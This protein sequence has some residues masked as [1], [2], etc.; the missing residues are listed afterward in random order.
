[1]SC[2]TERRAAVAR[3]MKDEGIACALVEDTEGRRDPSLRYL[4]GQ[5]GDAMLFLFDDGS[6]TLAAWDLNMAR[7]MADA[8]DLVALGDYGRVPERVAAGVLERRGLAPGSR[9]SLPASMSH[10]AF[11]RFTAALPAF[12]LECAEGGAGGEIERMRAIK[13][14]AE[15]AILR[16]AC[17]ITDE[18]GLAIERG[19]RGGSIRT[20]GDAALL[21]EA[22]CRRMGCE[23]TGFETLAAGPAR[24]FGIHCF[25]AWTA[26]PFGTAGL[27]ILDFGVKLEGYTSDVTLS[28]VREPLPAG[29]RH[30]VELVRSAYDAARAALRPGVASRDIALLV[31]GIFAAAGAS[32]PHA[33]GHGIGLEAHEAP[34]VRSRADNEWKL[35][36]GMVF[37]LE[38]GLYDPEGGGVRLEDDFL[39]GESAAE[40]LTHSR[41]VEL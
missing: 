18:I 2:Y 1:M 6:S 40:A 35:E 25:P 12:G 4:S 21:I 36:P 8:E 27:S 39:M 11:L 30:H 32:M 37:T 10:P 28:F 5:P 34:A 14:P 31:D 3:W 26:A 17:A 41:I 13:D 15:V 23:G 22:E 24:S 38:P 19:L 9:V 33:L 20:E 16:R 29:A 7:A